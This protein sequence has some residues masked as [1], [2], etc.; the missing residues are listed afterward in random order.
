MPGFLILLL[1]GKPYEYCF[2]YCLMDLMFNGPCKKRKKGFMLILRKPMGKYGNTFVY[3]DS[4]ASLNGRIFKNRVYNESLTFEL[5][6][7][8][9]NICHS[10][11]FD[12]RFMHSM[13]DTSMKKLEFQQLSS[14]LTKN[15]NIGRLQM[16][17][18]GR[19][20]VGF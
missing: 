7:S 17:L 8:L 20:M 11:A 2:S 9:Q 15:T 13:T 4:T 1:Y 14:K 12:F 16:A 3:H 6:N 5:S 19:R 10:R 18:H